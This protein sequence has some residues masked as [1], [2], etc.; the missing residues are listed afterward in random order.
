MEP[1]SYLK[2][3]TEGLKI[4]GSRMIYLL[5]NALLQLTGGKKLNKSYESEFDSRYKKCWDNNW[6]IVSLPAFSVKRVKFVMHE[7]KCYFIH[8]LLL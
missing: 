2:Y 3:Q 8:N 5:K 4:A 6:K 7:M 1:N